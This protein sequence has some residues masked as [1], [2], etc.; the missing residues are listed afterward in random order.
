M[1]GK[2]GQGLCLGGAGPRE[3]AASL[4]LRVVGLDAVGVQAVAE[5]VVQVRELRSLAFP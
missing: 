5:A 2:D 1:W 4:E 3:Q